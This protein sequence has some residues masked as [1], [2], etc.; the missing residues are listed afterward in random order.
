[1]HN[2]CVFNTVPLRGLADL[3]TISI[4]STDRLI[5]FQCRSDGVDSKPVG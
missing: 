5:D 1:M 3:E 4:I 2:L